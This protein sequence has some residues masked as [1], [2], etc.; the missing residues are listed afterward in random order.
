V[1]SY[2][3]VKYLSVRSVFL[4]NVGKYSP[5]WGLFL[6][7]SFMSCFVWVLKFPIVGVGRNYYVVC[8]G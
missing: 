7:E 4:A 8:Y 1:S 5:F 2:L 3:C 6:F